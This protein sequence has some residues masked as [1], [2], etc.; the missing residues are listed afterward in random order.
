[1]TRW[2]HADGTADHAPDPHYN[3]NGLPA[4]WTCHVALGKGV[5][6][7]GALRLDGAK[8]PITAPVKR[9][10]STDEP[11]MSAQP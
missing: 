2:T 7:D 3:G 6:C 11:A 8:V 10:Q 9:A 1:M 5:R 4:F